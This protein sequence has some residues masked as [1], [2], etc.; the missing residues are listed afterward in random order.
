MKG[1]TYVEEEE[2]QKGSSEEAEEGND[3]DV[4]VRVVPNGKEHLFSFSNHW[5]M[6]FN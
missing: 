4:E 1:W 5:T 3:P 6:H 2:H